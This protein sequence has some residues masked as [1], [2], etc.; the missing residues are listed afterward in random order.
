VQRSLFAI[1]L[2]IK[3]VTRAIRKIIRKNKEIIKRRKEKIQ[4]IYIKNKK[5][6]K[7]RSTNQNED[8]RDMS[9]NMPVGSATCLDLFI[10]AFQMHFFL[11][12]RGLRVSKPASS[13]ELRTDGASLECRR[14][15]WSVRPRGAL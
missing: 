2:N 10:L 6:A 11:L 12:C 7:I 4:K 14:Y 15:G 5:F 9:D 3:R 8:S 13:T 1:S